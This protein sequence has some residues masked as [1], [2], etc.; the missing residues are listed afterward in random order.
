VIV[1]IVIAAVAVVRTR[2]KSK[3][4]EENDES[5][6]TREGD[7]AEEDLREEDRADLLASDSEDDS[8]DRE[9]GVAK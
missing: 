7:P 8:A 3:G 2:G 9:D 1:A 6:E 5:T 4:K